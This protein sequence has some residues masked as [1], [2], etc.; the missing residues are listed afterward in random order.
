MRINLNRVTDLQPIIV[1]QIQGQKVTGMLPEDRQLFPGVGQ[2]VPA[3][4][5]ELQL[6]HVL[7][8]HVQ[9]IKSIIMPMWYTSVFYMQVIFLHF[10]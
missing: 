8:T 4:V 3:Q 5:K 6:H 7:K 10:I 2:L 9:N 1:P